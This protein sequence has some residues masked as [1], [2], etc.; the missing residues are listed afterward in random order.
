MNA[1]ARLIGA[2]LLLC[3]FSAASAQPDVSPPLDSSPTVAAD[4][5]KG[6][7]VRTKSPA[8]AA[9]LSAL[10][11]GAGQVYNESYLK[12]PIVAGIGGYFIYQILHNNKLYGDYRGQYS[13]SLQTTSGG[14]A[15]LLSLRE[16]YHDERDRFG[17]YFLILYALNVL[18]A[19][20]DA[21]LFG[22]DVSDELALRV[23]PAA[24]P[25]LTPQP[26][27]GIRLNF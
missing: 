4:T 19:Y 11:P 18:D 14:D 16:F 8:L 27:L 6:L 12:V 7:P 3:A 25:A 22:F 26:L 23:L 15:E 13:R 1:G 9:G 21:S 24:G 17:W 2:A 20:V 5:G 10:L